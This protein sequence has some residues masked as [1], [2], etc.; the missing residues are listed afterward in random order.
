L[1]STINA[2][3]YE[4][5]YWSNKTQSASAAVGGI[6]SSERL[7]GGTPR[8][9]LLR[10]QITTRR[11]SGRSFPANAN[12]AGLLLVGRGFRNNGRQAKVFAVAVLLSDPLS[13]R[14]IPSLREVNE[15][16]IGGIAVKT[17]AEGGEVSLKSLISSTDFSA[18]WKEL[19]S[20]SAG[21]PVAN[22]YDRLPRP[23]PVGVNILPCDIRDEVSVPVAIAIEDQTLLPFLRVG[24][25][26]FATEEDP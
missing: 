13:T 17:S 19:S 4:I 6:H 3:C 1:S 16:K 10:N 20:R 12:F 15:N 23:S 18:T 11:M 21:E 25:K 22:F 26:P 5:G 14:W 24:P 2:I 9:E 7:E 8:P